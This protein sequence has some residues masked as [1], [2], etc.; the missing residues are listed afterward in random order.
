MV[1]TKIKAAVLD[2]LVLIFALPSAIALSGH[3]EKVPECNE[4]NRGQ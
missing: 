4:C 1:V 3:P 2:I